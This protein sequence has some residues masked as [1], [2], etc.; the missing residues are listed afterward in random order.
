MG[1]TV[2]QKKFKIL[3]MDKF[4]EQNL[5]ADYNLS[6]LLAVRDPRLVQ[7]HEVELRID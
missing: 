4:L 3:I 1:E 7:I 6:L 2:G 5:A